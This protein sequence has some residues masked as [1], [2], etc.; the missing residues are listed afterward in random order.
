MNE[1]DIEDALREDLATL[2]GLPTIVWPNDPSL[3]ALPYLVVEIVRFEPVARNLDSDPTFT[4]LLQVSVLI[5]EG[6]YNNVAK[7]YAED[8]VAQYPARR[9]IA[10][11]G[12]TVQIRKR[13]AILSGYPEKAISA[14]RLP[15]Q[16]PYRAFA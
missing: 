8:I 12:G 2:P 6:T 10:V 15:V 16:V 7:S 1:T 11:S 9:S 5:A 4:G 14:W 3:P 13:P